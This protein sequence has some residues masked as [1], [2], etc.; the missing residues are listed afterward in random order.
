MILHSI[1]SSIISR[2][3]QAIKNDKE[4]HNWEYQKLQNEAAVCV[5]DLR[6]K[7]RG[8]EQRNGEL[9]AMKNPSHLGDGGEL[10]IL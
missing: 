10:R 3:E 4:R 6:C 2:M 7:I 1:S 5:G 8:M 9:K